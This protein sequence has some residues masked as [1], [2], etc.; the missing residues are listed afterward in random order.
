MSFKLWGSL[1]LTLVFTLL[2]GVYLS[3]HMPAE[4]T[5]KAAS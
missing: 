1:G 2:Q 3:R 5:D 4:T